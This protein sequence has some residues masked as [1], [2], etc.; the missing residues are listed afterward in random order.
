MARS[1]RQRQGASP[2]AASQAEPVVEQE[3]AEAARRP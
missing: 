2:T 3:I 1:M